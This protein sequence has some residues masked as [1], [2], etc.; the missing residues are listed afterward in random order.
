[1]FTPTEV[2]AIAKVPKSFNKLPGLKVLPESYR[3]TLQEAVAVDAVTSTQMFFIV[4]A[5][6][7]AK[8]R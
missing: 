5:N 7:K 4:P 2:V 3:P 6:V 1:M 8:G